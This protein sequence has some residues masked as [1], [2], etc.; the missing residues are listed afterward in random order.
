VATISSAYCVLSARLLAIIRI[1]IWIFCHPNSCYVLPHC[2][3]HRTERQKYGSDAR[4]SIRDS[5]FS[6]RFSDNVIAQ[7]TQTHRLHLSPVLVG[8]NVWLLI[9][10]MEMIA[11]REQHTT[12]LL[13]TYEY[14]H[15]SAVLSFCAVWTKCLISEYLTRIVAQL[16]SATSILCYCSAYTSTH[17]LHTSPVHFHMN[18][19][20]LRTHASF[21]SRG[22]VVWDVR[23]SRRRV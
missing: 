23:L 12:L 2:S 5:S 15:P 21:I 16:L 22:T 10:V 19:R 11:V 4:H 17:Q 8:L 9:P 18:V 7:H 20:L 3:D 13:T 6:R 14:E 1:L